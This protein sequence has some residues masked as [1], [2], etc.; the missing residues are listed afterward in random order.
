[1]WGI[2]Y[3][4]FYAAAGMIDAHPA[5][6]AV[7]PQ[8]P[9]RRLVHRRRLPPQRRVLPRRTRSTSCYASASRGRSRRRKS[10][11][12][13]DHGTP[14]GYDFFLQMGPL[15]EREREVLQGRRIAFWNEIDASTPTTTS[16]GRRATSAPHL[17]EHQA[18]GDDRG[19]LVRRRG[20][21][22]RA[23]DVRG[24]RGAEPRRVEHP[25]DGPVVAR[26]LGAD[27]RRPL[28]DVDFDRRPRRSTASRSSCRSS[29]T[30]SRARATLDAARGV[31]LRDGHERVA[32]LRRLAAEERAAEDRCTSSAGGRLG[33]DAAAPDEPGDADAATTS[34]QRSGEARAVQRRHRHRHDA[35]VHG[36]RPALRRAAARRA[37]LRDRGRSTRT[38]RSPGRSRRP[39]RLDDRHRRR[40]GREA[41]STSI[42]DDYARSRPQPARACAWAATSSSCAAKS[43]RGQVPQQLREARAVRA[44]KR[45]TTV[46]FT[47]PDVYHTFRRGHRIMVQVQSTWFPLVDRN[48]Q[49]FVRTSTARS[50]GDFQ[51]ATQRVYHAP[52]MESGIAVSVLP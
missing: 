1:M 27:R 2:S 43:I 41:R 33:C 28:G 20:P 26:R 29:S 24:D 44:G 37:R 17:Q 49:T 31:G 12:G 38:S 13:F 5:L 36:R 52:G 51:K 45:S 21:L 14:D 18:R 22:R 50:V 48:P 32:A 4:G 16:S 8:A 46:E 6:K 11:G 15:A 9:D 10:A 35:R 34:T 19:R 7:S 23:R 47:M 3:P 25:R 39:V 40:L 42:P 30:T